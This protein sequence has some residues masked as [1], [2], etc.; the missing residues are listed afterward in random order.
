MVLP[1]GEDRPLSVYLSHPARGKHLVFDGGLLHCVASKYVVSRQAPAPSAAVAAPSCSSLPPPPP[2][3]K[4]ATVLVNI[5]LNYR[6][7]VM[8]LKTHDLARPVSLSDDTLMGDPPHTHTH[9][10][11]HARVSILS[12]SSDMHSD[13]YI[14]ST[15]HIQRSS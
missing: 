1:D 15:R 9:A 14:S 13:S 8:V 3:K 5:W 7:Q 12:T 4:R 11:S 10:Y 2:P 6:P